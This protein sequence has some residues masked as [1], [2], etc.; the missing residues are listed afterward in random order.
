MGLWGRRMPLDGPPNC[1]GQG[2]QVPHKWRERTIVPSKQKLG[3]GSRGRLTGPNRDGMI[4]PVVA[5]QVVTT[6]I[7]P[8]PRE[9]KAHMSTLLMAWW[10]LHAHAGGGRGQG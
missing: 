4:V 5:A 9:E 8:L 2:S 7:A 10:P 1:Q 3:A 6:V